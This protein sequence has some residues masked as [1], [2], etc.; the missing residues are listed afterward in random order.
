[1]ALPLVRPAVLLQCIDAFLKLLQQFAFALVFVVQAMPLI[2][3]ARA[4][5]LKGAFPVDDH[6]IAIRQAV[7]QPCVRGDSGHVCRG[8]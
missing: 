6:K 3:G 1:M 2:C 7:E 8:L 4:I 5:K